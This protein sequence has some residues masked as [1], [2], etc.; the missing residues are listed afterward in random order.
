MLY[1]ILGILLI[2]CIGP[3]VL[4]YLKV[5]DGKRKS[6]QKYFAIIS[7]ATFVFS[8]FFMQII[9]FRNMTTVYFAWQILGAWVIN[10]LWLLS[11]LFSSFVS[12]FV[13]VVYEISKHTENGLFNQIIKKRFPLIMVNFILPI[14]F[15]ALFILG[16]LWIALTIFELI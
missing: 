13:S 5:D 15:I 14:H 11:L 4:L 10:L 9:A 6:I 8:M 3:T 7:I 1:I 2:V 16:A 12:F